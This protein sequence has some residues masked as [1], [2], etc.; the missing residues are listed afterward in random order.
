MNIHKFWRNEFLDLV[1]YDN[2]LKNWL[3]SMDGK[4]IKTKLGINKSKNFV[5][6]KRG[7]KTKWV[8]INSYTP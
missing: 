6:K 1:Y 3:I 8:K 2:E 4:L 5:N 7:Q